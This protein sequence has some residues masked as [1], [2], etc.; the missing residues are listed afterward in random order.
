MKA[1]RDRHN[2]RITW[3]SSIRVVALPTD[4]KVNDHIEIH[5]LLFEREFRL[6]SY[7]WLI[8]N[9]AHRQRTSIIVRVDFKNECKHCD[10][11]SYKRSR[12]IL[13]EF[14]VQ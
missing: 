12:F 6:F 11:I 2:D 9:S 10:A 7:S 8:V 14:K 5:R 13:Y 1:R 3:Q 4:D